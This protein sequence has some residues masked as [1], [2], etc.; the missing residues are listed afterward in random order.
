MKTT[1]GGG[2][3]SLDF[4]NKQYLESGDG[5]NYLQTRWWLS[6]SGRGP[7]W[8][9]CGQSHLAGSKRHEFCGRVMLWVPGENVEQGLLAARAKKWV[10]RRR[11]W[12]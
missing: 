2:D 10:Q 1:A 11:G 12:G 9:C 3:L 4:Q 6:G 7:S 8:A 5:G